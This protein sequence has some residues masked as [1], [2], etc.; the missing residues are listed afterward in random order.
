[1]ESALSKAC[2]IK[3]Q[4][5]EGP[6]DLLFHLIE[7]NQF[8]IYDI[9]INEIADQYLDYL[10]KM[11]ELD[12][13]VASEFLVLASTLLHIK[14]KMLL[15]NPKEN[16]EDEVDP[17]EELILRLV[18]Y[19]KYKQFTEMLK[20]RE[21]E[22]EKVFFKGPE[23]IDIKA[24]NEPLELSVE[25][26]KGVYLS[27]IDR[28]ERKLN[29]STGK[30]THILQHEKVS[31]K[32]KIREVV[33]ALLNKAYFRFSELFSIKTKSKLEIVTGLLAVLE[34]AKLKKVTIVQPKQFSEIMVYKCEGDIEN[35]EGIE[36]IDDEKITAD[37]SSAV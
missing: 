22:W 30:M 3:I 11:Q 23:E 34:L 33:K 18:E 29:K 1:M 31:L 28:N 24:E 7:K 8:D 16:K 37:N 25:E 27:I 10:F 17:R 4:N 21:K 32:S 15:P 14:S 19:K 2:T 13:E 6:F 35:I 26:L 9:P 36:D 5:F 20:N 12:L